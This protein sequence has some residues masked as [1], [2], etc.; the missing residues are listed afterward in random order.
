MLLIINY[1]S[2]TNAEDK[3]I[4]E[5]TVCDSSLL[6]E[7]VDGVKKEEALSLYRYGI[8][9][10]KGICMEKN[11]RQSFLFF[12]KAAE[13]GSIPAYYNL[14]LMFHLGIGVETDGEKATHMLE[15]LITMNYEPAIDY[16][17]SL[18]DEHNLNIDYWKEKFSI[19]TQQ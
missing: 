5:V 18:S 8:M 11:E 15:K 17:C 3:L 10:Y 12:A 14:A 4:D 16:V 7:V 19:C 1:P 6:K 9:L 13:K 2:Y